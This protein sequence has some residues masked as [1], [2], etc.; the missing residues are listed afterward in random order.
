MRIHGEEE[1]MQSE[2]QCGGIAGSRSCFFNDGDI[3]GVPA[4]RRV[5]AIYIVVGLPTFT[6]LRDGRKTL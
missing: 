1:V 4:G 6:S 3:R 5:L 2:H